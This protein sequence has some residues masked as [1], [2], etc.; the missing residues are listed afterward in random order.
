MITVIRIKRLTNM[1]IDGRTDFNSSVMPAGEVFIFNSE[2][3]CSECCTFML[4]KSIRNYLVFRN[5][6]PVELDSDLYEF[7]R[8]L[9]VYK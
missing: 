9:E 6:Y 8:K 4:G 5:G 3:E 2:T 7:N 1:D